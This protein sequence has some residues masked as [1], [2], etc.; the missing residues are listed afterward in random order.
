M[1]YYLSSGTTIIA[2]TLIIWAFRRFHLKVSNAPMALFTCAIFA[3]IV[4]IAMPHIYVIPSSHLYLKI[5]FWLI[6]S[7]FFSWII[8]YH[9]D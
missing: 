6:F 2:I 1:I 7:L 9:L 4:V 3:F 8:A 5:F